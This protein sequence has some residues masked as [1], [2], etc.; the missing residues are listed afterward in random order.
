RQPVR[1][2]GLFRLASTLSTA[3]TVPMV[4]TGRAPPG[5][6]SSDPAG[7]GA[8][9]TLAGDAGLAGESGVSTLSGVTGLSPGEV[10][11][12]ADGGESGV[13]TLSGVTGLSPGEVALSADGGLVTE[14]PSGEAGD[15]LADAKPAVIRSVAEPAAEGSADAVAA[16]CSLASV[17][18]SGAAELPL[19]EVRVRTPAPRPVTAAPVMTVFQGLR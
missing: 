9:G 14:A 16:T 4:Q 19:I 6:E 15:S 11:L 5:Q 17:I 1:R 7:L 8:E 18:G 2:R 10:G 12:A 13:S 3:S